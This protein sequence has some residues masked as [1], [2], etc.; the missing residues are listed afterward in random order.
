MEFKQWL[1]SDL[2]EVFGIFGQPDPEKQ[3][4]KSAL[5]C[6][7]CGLKV[8][9]RALHQSDRD[10]EMLSYAIC[11]SCGIIE[12]SQT[13]PEPSLFDKLRRVAAL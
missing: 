2:Q 13:M 8:K 6:K 3:W 1:E 4:L 10:G 7:K 11:P 12:K 9:P 5:K